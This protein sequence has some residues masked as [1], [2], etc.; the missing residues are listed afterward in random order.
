M[1]DCTYA[2]VFLPPTKSLPVALPPNKELVRLF[3]RRRSAWGHFWLIRPSTS[4]THPFPCSLQ[5]KLSDPS[6]KLLAKIQKAC[7]PSVRRLDCCPLIQGRNSFWTC[8]WPKR[9]ATYQWT[10]GKIMSG[11]KMDT[12]GE[13]AGT[14]QSFTE[15]YNVL[16]FKY[17]NRFLPCLSLAT[18]DSDLR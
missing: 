14:Y 6:K 5:M 4:F 13:R 1:Y 16:S 12:F 8:E 10:E 11:L 3:S 2:I 7:C 9:N 17:G 15:N 18:C